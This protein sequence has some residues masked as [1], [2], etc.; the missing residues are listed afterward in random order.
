MAWGDRQGWQQWNDK[1][2]KG[3][4]RSSEPKGSKDSGKAD[5]FPAYDRGQGGGNGGSSTSST[6]NG[7][8]TQEHLIQALLSCEAKDKNLATMVESLVPS[9]YSE[10]QELRSQQQ[11]LNKIRKLRQ[12]IA[13]KET[14]ISTKN[15]MMAQFLE[16]MKSHV[17]SEKNRHATEIKEM[18]TEVEEL[19]QEL[20]LLKSGQDKPSEPDIPLEE[21]FE[22]DVPKGEKM[23]REQL[24]K[25][26]AEA[27]EAQNVAYAMQ[28]Q[29]QAFMEYQQMMAGSNGPLTVPGAPPGLNAVPPPE[30][31]QKPKPPQHGLARDARAP[32]G[33]VRTDGATLRDSPYSKSG[34]HRIPLGGPLPTDPPKEELNSMKHMD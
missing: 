16:E 7:S 17:T 22:D 5:R 31:P 29:M 2:N 10:E 27:K 1:K 19:K 33:V 26:Q 8:S 11:S 21:I 13:K 18:E 6:S 14:A 20:A 12:R 28:A 25:A 15:E 24:E 4:R 23:L 30:S 3:Q 32:F 9:T 34:H